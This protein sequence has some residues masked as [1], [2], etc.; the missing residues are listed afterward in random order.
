M[1]D[2]EQSQYN[3]MITGF[4]G[5]EGPLNIS[6][7][8]AKRR[9][10]R[11]PSR[12]GFVKER[13]GSNQTRTESRSLNLGAGYFIRKLLDDKKRNLK[14]EVYRFFKQWHRDMKAEFNVDM[15]P[16]FN[17][18]DPDTL[19]E[20]LARNNETL[21]RF[22]RL[23]LKT[24]LADTG[25]IKPKVLNSIDPQIL[26][27]KAAEIL[28][29][30]KKQVDPDRRAAI[31]QALTTLNCHA[32]AAE[33][34]WYSDDK[35]SMPAGE[36]IR[37]FADEI[38][39]VLL[40][41]HAHCPLTG[42]EAVSGIR[43][44]GIEFEFVTRDHSFLELGKE[45]GDCTA[46]KKPFQLDGNVENIFWTVFSWLLDKHYQILKVYFD[47]EF[48]MKIHLTPLYVTE[49]M[50]SG[51]MLSP[52]K[53]EFIFLAVD[54]IET[55]VAF[56]DDKTRHHKKHLMANKDRIFQA[57]MDR[58]QTL[59]DAMG[60]HHIYAE[61]FS[62]TP[63]IREI[64]DDYPEIFF[65]IDHL[66]KIDQ[67]EDVFCLAEQLSTALGYTPPKEIFMELQMKNTYLSPG[68]INKAPGVKSYALIRGNGEDGIPMKR[69]IGV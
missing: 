13:R 7:I 30:R 17:I 67:L 69:I 33:L 40:K 60:I 37:T 36:E 68:Y 39:T 51:P 10:G 63:W 9:Y 18:N 61:K 58:I 55:T 62:N 46:D 11:L 4:S 3:P 23:D 20:I 47:G 35:K 54:A 66:I 41:I 56:R 19:R 53:S 45:T 27:R 49:A 31:D 59:A 32:L 43:G 52:T 22:F 6:L 12:Y 15:G 42:M 48:V 50:A 25:L 38:T 21:R 5:D 8:D 34:K 65:N 44:S 29:K 2:Q 26:A 16:F 14:R 28:T 64:F 57:T 24:F 1:P